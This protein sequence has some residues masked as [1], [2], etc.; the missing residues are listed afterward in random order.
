[1]L[2]GG[3]SNPTC[4]SIIGMS[5]TKASVSLDPAKVA[6]ARELLGVPTLSE[7]IDIALD[8]L[9]VDELERRHAAGYLRL[10]PDQDDN[11]WAEVQRESSGIADDVDWAGLYGVARHQ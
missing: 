1:M 4:S 2:L 5:K 11:A 10:P 7:L 3:T 9:I 8:R 6:Q